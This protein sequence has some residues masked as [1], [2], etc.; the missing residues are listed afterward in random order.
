[1]TT[2][3]TQF[4]HCDSRVL[5]APGECEF[6]DLHPEWQELREG[7]GISFTGHQPEGDWVTMPCPADAAR[8]QGASNDHRRWGGNTATGKRGDPSQ[9]RQTTASVMMYGDQGGREQWPLGERTRSALARPWRN[10]GMRRRGWRR[11]GMFWRYG[12]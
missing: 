12:K 9:P 6:C 3:I 1:M 2:L 8:P 5:H 11:D 10:L 4:P 7:W